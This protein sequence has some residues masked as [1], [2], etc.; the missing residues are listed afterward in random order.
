[1]R[2]HWLSFW[3]LLISGA[4]LITAGLMIAGGGMK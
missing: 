4:A 1:M 2:G 3:A